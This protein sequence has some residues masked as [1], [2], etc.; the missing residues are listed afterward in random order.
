MVNNYDNSNWVK[1]DNK[2]RIDCFKYSTGLSNKQTR[3]V[4]S[5]TISNTNDEYITK[6][7]EKAKQK[8][9]FISKDTIVNI[10]ID[11]LSKNDEKYTGEEDYND[12]IR[13]YLR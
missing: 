11:Y 12:W 5:L 2:E 3:K 9:Q 10:A 1:L 6:I 8:G 13:K 4:R 7:Q